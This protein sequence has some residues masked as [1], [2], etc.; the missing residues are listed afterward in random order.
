MFFGS[1][2]QLPLRER[3]GGG[4]ERIDMQ[5]DRQ[6]GDKPDLRSIAQPRRSRSVEPSPLASPEGR[7]ARA[8]KWSSSVREQ[9]KRPETHTHQAPRDD[10]ERD[11]APHRACPFWYLAS[12]RT[13]TRADSDELG[14][15]KKKEN[16][17]RGEDDL[18]HG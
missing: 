5:H 1:D 6:V 2:K 12:Y 4:G 11:W 7:R 8:S 14:E 10:W 17:G 16:L 3:E 9:K 15:R 18:G 13:R